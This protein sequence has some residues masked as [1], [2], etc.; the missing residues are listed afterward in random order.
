MRVLTRKDRTFWFEIDDVEVCIRP[1]PAGELMRIQRKYTKRKLIG[2]ELHEETDA[3]KLT[4]ELFTRCVVDWKGLE[5]E[6]GKP[7]PCNE[8][9]KKVVAELN[10]S[11]ASEVIKRATQIEQYLNSE[12]LKNSDAGLNGTLSQT[13]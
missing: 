8:E 2:G 1:I 6:E 13:A 10:S 11:F 4:Q 9:T 12:E 5:D 7:L 3:V